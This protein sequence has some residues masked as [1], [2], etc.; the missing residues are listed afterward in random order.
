MN[1]N[2]TNTKG[3]KMNAAQIKLIADTKAILA[4]LEAIGTE[5]AA[6]AARTLIARTHE[7][8]GTVDAGEL[9]REIAG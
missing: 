9:L 2:D 4:D 3:T 1:G 5:Q 8:L 7:M 6:A